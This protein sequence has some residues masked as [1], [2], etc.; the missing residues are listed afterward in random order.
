MDHV[1]TI[2]NVLIVCGVALGAVLIV[3]GLFLLISIMN[4]FRSGH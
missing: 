1:I 4:P 2:G 3:G